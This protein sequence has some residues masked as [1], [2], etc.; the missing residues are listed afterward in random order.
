MKY[1][2]TYE[3]LINI[4][5]VKVKDL[6]QGDFV[7]INSSDFDFQNEFMYLVEDP[8]ITNDGFLIK[9]SKWDDNFYHGSFTLYDWEIHY[10]VVGDDIQKY[11]DKVMFDKNVKQYNL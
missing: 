4:N 5:N 7:I 3:S 10:K 2:K 8:E 11:K 1:I 9:A 6:K